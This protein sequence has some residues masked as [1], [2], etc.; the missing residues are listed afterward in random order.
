MANVYTVTASTSVVL[1]NTL[2]TPNTVVLLSSVVN[3]G[4][5]VGIRDGTGSAL[6]ASRPIVISTTRGIKFYDG[7]FSTLLTQPN[8]SLIVSSRNP[9]TWQILNNQAFFTSLSSVAL[10]QVTTSYGNVT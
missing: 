6:I 5:I 8:T 1:I 3:P 2:Q 7:S 10:N 4:H 9:T